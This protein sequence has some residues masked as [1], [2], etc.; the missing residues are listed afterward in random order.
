M[1]ARGEG[2]AGG[3]PGELDGGRARPA[4]GA[5]RVG[6]DEAGGARRVGEGRGRSS[7][8]GLAG[9]VA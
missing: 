4:R 8:P 1:T 3:G 6:K 2:G 7:G 9:E 5:R